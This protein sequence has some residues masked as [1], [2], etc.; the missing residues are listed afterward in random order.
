MAANS[1]Q[2]V[3][4]GNLAAVLN[5]A[6]IGREVLAIGYDD[7]NEVNVGIDLTKYSSLDIDLYDRNGIGYVTVN[8]PATLGRHAVSAGQCTHISITQELSGTYN[9][10]TEHGIVYLCRIVGIRSVGGVS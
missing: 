6:G 8:I 5:D 1:E 2:P 9:L 4:V 7:T 10:S 3:S